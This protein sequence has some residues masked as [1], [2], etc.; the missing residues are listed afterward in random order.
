MSIMGN[1]SGRRL[2]GWFQRCG[3]CGQKAWYRWW[4]REWGAV[5]RCAEHKMIPP[6]WEKEYRERVAAENAKAYRAFMEWDDEQRS[7]ARLRASKA[8]RRK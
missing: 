8:R 6:P 2:G 7:L 3:I 1:V 4:D 5:A